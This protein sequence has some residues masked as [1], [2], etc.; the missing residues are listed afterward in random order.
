V[1]MRAGLRVGW[2]TRHGH[3]WFA[4]LERS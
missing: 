1:A 2:T 4:R 3:R